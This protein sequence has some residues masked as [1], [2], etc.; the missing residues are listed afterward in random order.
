MTLARISRRDDEIRRV[1]RSRAALSSL[2]NKRTGER[3]DYLPVD[4]NGIGF[5][6]LPPL[7]TPPATL[8]SL[9]L[10]AK[11]NLETCVFVFG[12]NLLFVFLCLWK[13]APW[14]LFDEFHR[15]DVVHLFDLSN[16]RHYFRLTSFS[17]EN[18]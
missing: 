6:L 14:H 16:V 3:S 12:A 8:Y 11:L 7:P 2:G 4:P 1:P 15:L 9:S 5:D 17:R 13:S 10:G 18:G